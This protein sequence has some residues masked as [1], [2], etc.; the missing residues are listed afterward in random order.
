MTETQTQEQPTTDQIRADRACV[1]CGFNLYGQT[2]TREAHYGLAIARCPECGTV[3]ALQQYPAMTHWVNRFRMIIAAIYVLLLVAFF[4]GSTVGVSAFAF[5]ASSVASENLRRHLSDSNQ[6]WNEQQ[7]TQQTTTGLPFYTSNL[8]QEYIEEEFPNAIEDFGPLWGNMDPEWII[9]L[10]PAVMVCFTIGVFW[11]VA[12]LGASRKRTLLVPLISCAIG[13]SFII[14]AN[15]PDYNNAWIWNLAHELY[16]PS[17]TPVVILIEFVALACG[18]WLG[19]KLA[20]FTVRVALPPRSRV[21]LSILW[22]RDGLEL[23][24]P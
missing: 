6:A 8:S 2:V 3:A 15:R 11:S 10:V 16:I 18:V 21:P 13:C 19:R 9:V 1:G 20:R 22:S 14:A 12:L 24:R 17:M 23:P 5:G 4:V 7:D